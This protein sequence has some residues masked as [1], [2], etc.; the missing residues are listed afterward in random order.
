MERQ[1]WLLQS[2]LAMERFLKRYPRGNAREGEDEVPI[3]RMQE[4]NRT[5][6]R[7]MTT[8]NRENMQE[9]KRAQNPSEQERLPDEG[10]KNPA[11]RKTWSDGQQPSAEGS[12]NLRN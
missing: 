3:G 8:E 2:D 5:G 12:E 9:Y 6:D 11:H 1:A 10:S 7:M 4:I